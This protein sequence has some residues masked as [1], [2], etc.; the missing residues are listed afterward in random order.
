MGGLEEPGHIAGK[1]LHCPSTWRKVSIGW[2]PLPRP[3][4][5][6]CIWHPVNLLVTSFQAHLFVMSLNVAKYHFIIG[7]VKLKPMQPAVCPLVVC[8]LWGRC[9]EIHKALAFHYTTTLHVLFSWLI[10]ADHFTAHAS[11]SLQ[12]LAPTPPALLL[13]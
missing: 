12:N 2:F 10:F 9:Q 3:P 1:S 6:Y 5:A 13:C 11:E 4:S 7:K 8:D